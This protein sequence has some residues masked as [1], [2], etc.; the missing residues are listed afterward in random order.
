MAKRPRVKVSRSG[1][2]QL[3]LGR[4]SLDEEVAAI[5]GEMAGEPVEEIEAALR[6]RIMT[7]YPAATMTEEN[8]VELRRIAEEIH[9]DGAPG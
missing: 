2:R 7:R 3:Q 5:R 1:M 6:A 4:A 8:L 9:A